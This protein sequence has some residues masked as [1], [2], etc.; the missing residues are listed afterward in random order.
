MI[1]FSTFRSRAW[2]ID[3]VREGG[4]GLAVTDGKVFE[5]RKSFFG[6]FCLMIPTSL[7]LR[8]SS[9]GKIGISYLLIW[10]ASC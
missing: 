8:S 6:C 10:T 7:L 9:S 4:K 5:E 3:H 1:C 2:V